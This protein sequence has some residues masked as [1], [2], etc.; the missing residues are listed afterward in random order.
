MARLKGGRAKGEVQLA[1]AQSILLRRRPD[2]YYLAQIDGRAYD[3]GTP[4]G[5]A[6]TLKALL[7]RVRPA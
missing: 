4:A 5:Y 6:A 3:T 7:P 1:D 2:E